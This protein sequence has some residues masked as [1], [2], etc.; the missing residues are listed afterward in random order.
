MIFQSKSGT[1]YMP[2]G[3]RVYKE[4]TTEIKDIATCPFTGCNWSEL[5]EEMDT[6][7]D[8]IQR[9]HGS[10]ARPIPL[11]RPRDAIHVVVWLRA[12]KFRKPLNVRHIVR[13]RGLIFEN[14]GAMPLGNGENDA[15]LAHSIT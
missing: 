11:V 13:S 10:V 8:V 1:V 12:C 7:A 6:T 4:F 3:K 15:D 14:D 5:R 2:V 9:D